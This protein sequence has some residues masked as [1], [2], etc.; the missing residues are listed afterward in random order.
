MM[1][2][3]IYYLLVPLKINIDEEIK[4]IIIE[5]FTRFGVVTGD[6]FNAAAAA[7]CC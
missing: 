6:C 7:N 4:R 5:N 3:E 1:F 2:V